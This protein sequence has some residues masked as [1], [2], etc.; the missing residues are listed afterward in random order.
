M[1][2]SILPPM[3]D[4]PK[5]FRERLGERPGRQRVMAADGHLL[6]VLHLPPTADEVQRR[7]R[8][9]WRKPDGSWTSNDVGGGVAGLS[10]HLAEYADAVQKFDVMEE[11][12]TSAAD[13]F[14]VLEGLAPLHRAASHL[15]LVLQ[16][17][18]KTIPE[19]RNLINFRDL[20]YEIERTADLLYANAKN[21]LDFQV[22]RRAEEESRSSRQMAVSAFRL[23]TLAAFFFP[24]VTLCA[25]LGVNM[26]TG[27]EDLPPPLPIATLVVAGLV[28]G[29]TL[30]FAI[31]RPDRRC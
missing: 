25:V 23:N 4:V 2:R 17:A 7:G 10:K 27:V 28:L 30:A 21:A 18:R 6:L 8:F 5:V 12:A 1:E 24:L 20:S 15:H 31:N 29:A 13:Y 11:R 19:D 9:F 26:R 14:E 16:E 22:A 3:W